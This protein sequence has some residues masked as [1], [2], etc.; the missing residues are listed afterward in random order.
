[1]G[2]LGEWG[3]KGTRAD[4]ATPYNVKYLWH[5]MLK[6]RNLYRMLN[7]FHVNMQIYTVSLMGFTRICKFI[8]CP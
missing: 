5:I 7:G 1:M 3:L 6:I 4:T 2:L 8:W